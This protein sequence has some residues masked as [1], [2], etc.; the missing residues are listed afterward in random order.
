MPEISSLASTCCSGMNAAIFSSTNPT[1]YLRRAMQVE[2]LRADI[3]KREWEDNAR[4]ALGA[5]ASLT[6][7]QEVLAEAANMAAQ[8]SQMLPAL[9]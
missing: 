7:L 9:R 5:K 8:D 1:A 2:T 6:G 4:K 3:R